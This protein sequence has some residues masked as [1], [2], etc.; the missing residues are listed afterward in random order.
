MLGPANTLAQSVFLRGGP[1]RPAGLRASRLDNLLYAG[2]FT[3]PGVGL[4]MCLIS[5]E[6]VVKELRGDTSGG[7][8]ESL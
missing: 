3:A 1:R 4:P 6:N 7:W 8:L 2:A 5:A